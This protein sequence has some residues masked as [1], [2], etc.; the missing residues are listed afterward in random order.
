MV[1][2]KIIF[3]ALGRHFTFC[4]HQQ[5]LKYTEETPSSTLIYI[6]LIVLTSKQLG[7]IQRDKSA[8]TRFREAELNVTFRPYDQQEQSLSRLHLGIK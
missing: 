5:M 4:I 2:V 1:K 8:L 7:F 6:A 3:Y